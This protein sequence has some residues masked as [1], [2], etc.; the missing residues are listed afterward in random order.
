MTENNISELSPHDERAIRDF[1]GNDLSKHR[2]LINK[3]TSGELSPEGHFK[4]LK[5]VDNQ[6]I[7]GI[8][9]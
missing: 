2:D 3:V 7:N 1:M 9:F 6:G 5:S 8:M 4:A